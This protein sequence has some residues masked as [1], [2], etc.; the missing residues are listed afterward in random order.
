[1]THRSDSGSQRRA[2]AHPSASLPGPE[3]PELQ[4]ELARL[5]E[6]LLG[7]FGQGASTEQVQAHTR[8]RPAATPP[9]P[10]LKQAVQPVADRPDTPFAAAE[11]PPPGLSPT[12]AVSVV[13]GFVLGVLATALLIRGPTR[14]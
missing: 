1:M 9:P 4:A 3:V 14:R 6:N 2:V 11:G 7:G 12:P 13:A 5:R 8:N 10:P